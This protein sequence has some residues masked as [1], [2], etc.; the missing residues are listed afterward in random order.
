MLIFINYAW[1]SIFSLLPALL[2]YE[3][4][5]IVF[6]SLK[7]RLGDYLMANWEVVRAL[8]AIL[9]KR[10]EVQALKGRHDRE[11]LSGGFMNMR[12]DVAGG[13][14][15][16]GAYQALNHFFSAYWSCARYLIA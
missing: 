14:L 15:M 16:R 13:P 4:S 1:R 6:L 5:L 2:V 7:G 8:P 11:I 12:A 3:C 9:A 10:R